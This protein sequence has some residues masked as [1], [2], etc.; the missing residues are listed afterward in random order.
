MNKDEYK[1][2]SQL[3][4]IENKI[5][6]LYYQLY[7]LELTKISETD[8]IILELKKYLQIEKDIYDELEQNSDL[9]NNILNYFTKNYKKDFE[10]FD[11]FKQLITFDDSI[12]VIRI[13]AKLSKNYI[14]GLGKLLSN[15][16]YSIF[17]SI[18]DSFKTKRN[19]LLDIVRCFLSIIESKTELNI[20]ELL[21]KSKY[22]ISYLYPEI[23][24]EMINTSFKIN[25]NP[26]ISYKMFCQFN[27][28]PKEII[29]TTTNLYCSEY[30]VSTINSMLQY[31]DADLID[32]TI[33]SELIVSQSFLRAIFILLDDETIMELNSALHDMID[34]EDMQDILQNKEKIVD[35]IINAYRKVKKD[36]AIPKIISLKL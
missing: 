16:D 30:Y 14:A 32:K 36:R 19:I 18:D 8:K 15:Q 26:Y 23:E 22:T 7:K 11:F 17:S 28:W 5:K 21:K 9:N 6:N 3:V 33:K 20:K 27:G 31:T 10:E 2:V 24:E 1:I 25:Y 13:I 35:M 4:D 34:D 12:I 29:N